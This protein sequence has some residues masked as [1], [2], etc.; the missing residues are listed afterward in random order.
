MLIINNKNFLGIIII[1]SIILSIN[2]VI[3]QD[4]TFKLND[5][6]NFTIPCTLNGFPCSDSASCNL[7]IRFLNN[8]YKI[9]NQLMSDMGNGDFSFGVNFT[10]LEPLSYKVF[11]IESGENDTAV[12]NILITPT[13][14]TFTEGQGTTAI[15]IMFG[16]LAVSFLFLIIGFS[17]EKK[18]STMI[19]GF[20]F[21]IFSIF[22]AVY[23]LHLGYVY[24]NDILQYESLIP[25]SSGIYTIILFSLGGLAVISGALMLIAFIVE[26]GK[27]NKTKKFGEGFNPITNTYD[28]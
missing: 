4:F 28:F 27:M 24:A 2:L 8:S 11:C 17:L 10:S 18:P 3:S 5:E 21:I 20:F 7:T 19:L 1:F 25:V 23:S 12:G 26:L 14:R 9:N 16:A 13:G 6:A 15:G 22:L